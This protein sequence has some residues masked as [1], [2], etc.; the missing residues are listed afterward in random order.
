VVADLRG[1]GVEPAVV[2]QV[3]AGPAGRIGV[4]RLPRD[5]RPVPRPQKVALDKLRQQVQ[6]AIDQLVESGAERGVQVAVYRDG[7][8]VVDAV[9]GVA[10]PDSGRAVTSGTVF[11]NFSIVKGATACRS[12]S[13]SASL[14]AEVRASSAS[15][16]IIGRTAGTAVVGSS[17]D[18]RG[19]IASSTNP[20]LGRRERRYVDPTLSSDPEAARKRLAS[21]GHPAESYA[22]SDG[23]GRTL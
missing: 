14:A 16:P 1:R 23:H 9:A 18:H 12:I 21:R 3:L 7:R 13:S 20:Q 11:Y 2:G 15:H 8:Q 6:Q 17:A 10:D 19:L 4:R 22:T 5:E